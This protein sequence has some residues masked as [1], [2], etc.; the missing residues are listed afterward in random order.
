MKTAAALLLSVC[1]ILFSA[2]FGL[3]VIHSSGFPFSADIAALDIAETSG[4][5]RGEILRNYN[6]VTAYLSPF[7]S[8]EF[9][10]PTLPWTEVSTVHFADC[11]VLFN[12]LYLLGAL[13]ALT[14]VFLWRKKLMSRRVLRI[15]GAVTLAVPALLA[16]VILTD[17]GATFDAFHALLFS[18]GTWLLNPAQDG[19]IRILP[20]EFFLHC[21]LFIAAFWVVSGAAQLLLGCKKIKKGM[22]L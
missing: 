4:L 11:K 13:S 21:A 19:I 1:V 15:S 17:F 12:W 8:D 14:I 6:A 9:S 3:A 16:A 22:A 20:A 18:E 10:L 2:A 7:S 5:S